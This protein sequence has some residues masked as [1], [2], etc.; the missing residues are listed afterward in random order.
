MWCV[1]RYNTHVHMIVTDWR[2]RRYL[3]NS[4]HVWWIC[5]VQWDRHKNCSA[6]AQLKQ[7]NARPAWVCTCMLVHGHVQMIVRRVTCVLA[8]DHQD[9]M[10]GHMRARDRS[11]R[12]YAG[13]CS[14]QII[15]TVLVLIHDCCTCATLHAGQMSHGIML[16]TSDACHMNIYVSFRISAF[17]LQ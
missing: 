9:R 17:I 2:T 12:S 4:M 7:P 16:A 10:Q 6:F 14:R 5:D 11:S 15:H 8:T 13:L 1:K 3:Q